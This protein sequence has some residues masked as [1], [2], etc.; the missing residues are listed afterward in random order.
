MAPHTATSHTHTP[1]TMWGSS[2]KALS[3]AE[4][5]ARPPPSSLLDLPCSLV[6]R[7]VL[8][9]LHLEIEDAPYDAKAPCR[10]L[11]SLACT[12]RALREALDPLYEDVP[13]DN[14]YPEH[15]CHK[16]EQQ[17]PASSGS[18]SGGGEPWLRSWYFD[19]RGYVR[20]DDL[21]GFSLGGKLWHRAAQHLLGDAYCNLHVMC[22]AFSDGVT[23]ENAVF[24]RK[25]CRDACQMTTFTYCKGAP[26]VLKHNAKIHDEE[27]SRRMASDPDIVKAQKVLSQTQTPR[28]SLFPTQVA[29]PC[30][31]CFLPGGSGRQAQQATPEPAGTAPATPSPTPTA[32]APPLGS[33][34]AGPKSAERLEAE[35]L[36]RTRWRKLSASLL[37]NKRLPRSGHCAVAMGDLV[38]IAGGFCPVNLPIVDVLVIHTDTLTIECPEV[39]GVPPPK[40]FKQTLSRIRPARESPLAQDAATEDHGVLI[41]YGGW[42]ALGCE[43]GGSEI[44]TLT[45]SPDGKTVFWRSFQVRNRTFLGMSPI[46][47]ARLHLFPFFH[48]PFPS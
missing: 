29:G 9:S 6:E 21:H 17:D 40:R 41:M 13:C 30:K 25:L 32:A 24:W 15:R 3:L 47:R 18:S 23:R 22:G 19:A 26:L 34:G 7:I 37:L 39:I 8:E 38:V 10:T 27:T 44:H 48:S 28:C 31:S 33:E 45:V 16:R 46:A 1:R 42:D 14:P 2:G 5:G 20:T 36:L 35:H 43:Y 12:N 4:E 11:A